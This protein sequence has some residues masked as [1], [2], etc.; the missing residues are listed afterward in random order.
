MLTSVVVLA[1]ISLTVLL[2][3][4][5]RLTTV[6][7][8]GEREG[9]CCTTLRM[10]CTITTD[11]LNTL[12]TPYL[13]LGNDVLETKSYIPHMHTLFGQHSRTSH[14][15]SSPCYTLRRSLTL[16]S[17]PSGL[18]SDRHDNLGWLG[19]DRVA[20][21]SLLTKTCVSLSQ[22]IS[23][24]DLWVCEERNNHSLRIGYGT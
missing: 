20:G 17:S 19:E 22:D 5:I 12:A 10:C 15:S 6:L 3:P 9:G 7:L 23:L 2:L 16:L 14:P 4:G 1:E 13:A 21:C 8:M 18:I 24:T 11:N